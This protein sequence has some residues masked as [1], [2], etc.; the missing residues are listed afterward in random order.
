MNHHHRH[1]CAGS[2]LKVLTAKL[3]HFSK[4]QNGAGRRSVGRKPEGS[5]DMIDDDPNANVN[6]VRPTVMKAVDELKRQRFKDDDIADA[7]TIVGA[8]LVTARRR[9]SDTSRLLELMALVLAIQAKDEDKQP[10][11]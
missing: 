10:K 7:V 3:P 4:E 11:H 9:A 8:E 5:P 6:A 1:R 2:H